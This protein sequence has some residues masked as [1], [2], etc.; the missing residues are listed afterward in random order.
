[1]L[2]VLFLIPAAASTILGLTFLAGVGGRPV[3]K[4]LGISV[5][6]AAV[7]LQFFSIYPLTGLILQTVLAMCL[8][9]WRKMDST[10]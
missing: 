2:P 8:A 9:L 5:F 6:F 1:M 10:R 7:Y 3:I 4:I